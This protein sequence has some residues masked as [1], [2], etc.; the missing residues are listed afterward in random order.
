MSDAAKKRVLIVED[1]PDTA[2][3]LRR[4]LEAEG[5]QVLN[6]TDGLEGL[7]VARREKPDCIVL[8]LML[9]R[10]DGFKV[11]S[12]LKLDS[13]FRPIP[14]IM[15][16]ARAH[17]EDRKRALD[18]GADVFLTKPCDMKQLAMKIREL[19]NVGSPPV[20]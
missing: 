5:F 8:D 15:L 11:C 12:M 6:G 18:V 16:T 14:I 7:N 13:R 3:L 19:V 10:M 17:A 1:E 4:R 20:S 2:L 9:P